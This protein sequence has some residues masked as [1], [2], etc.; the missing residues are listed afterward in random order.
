MLVIGPQALTGSIV[1]AIGRTG[2]LFV[3]EPPSA[4][5]ETVITRAQLAL[6]QDESSEG[7]GMFTSEFA[8]ALAPVVDRLASALDGAELQPGKLHD[9]PSLGLAAEL[10]D[11]ASVARVQAKNGPP[12][13]PVIIARARSSASEMDRI[14]AVCAVAK[15]LYRVACGP[16]TAEGLPRWTIGACFDRHGA[17][18]DGLVFTGPRQ[19]L[20]AAVY[21]REQ[22]V[23]LDA[24]PDLAALSRLVGYAIRGE[25]VLAIQARDAHAVERAVIDWRGGTRTALKL[26]AGGGCDVEAVA[27]ALRVALAWAL[28][29]RA[30]TRLLFITYKPLR[31]IIEAALTDGG[32]PIAQ[33]FEQWTE[34]GRRTVQFLHYGDVRGY[35]EFRGCDVSITFGDPVANLD[36]TGRE[37]AHLGIDDADGGR[38]TWLARREL[39]QAHGRL[40]FPSRKKPARALHVGRVEHLPLGP[41]W[42]RARVLQMPRGRVAALT[43]AQVVEAI[44]MAGSQRA[45]AELLGRSVSSVQ[46]AL[47]RG[48]ASDPIHHR[49]EDPLT[50]VNRVAPP[51]GAETQSAAQ[52]PRHSNESTIDKPGTPVPLG[53]VQAVTPKAAPMDHHQFTQAVDALAKHLRGYRPTVAAALGVKVGTFDAYC[54]RP[55]TAKHRTPPPHIVDALRAALEARGVAWPAAE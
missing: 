36:A 6:L 33:P 37:V 11:L 54:A 30:A 3:D 18:L 32:S 26:G 47:K 39:E 49:K 44:E 53:G 27:S 7:R 55:G 52:N 1:D 29:D 40:R 22:L 5:D 25:N 45:A 50:M 31:A 34:G 16:L 15:L 28:E 38:S 48:G 13:R 46:R 43:P 20:E 19:E 8:R 14:G 9:A 21:G 24:A 51:A 10:E 35:D 17:R 4:I 42:D 2:K 23:F 41:G 12:V